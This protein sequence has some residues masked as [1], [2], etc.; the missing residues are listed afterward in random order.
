MS[1]PA[2]EVDKGFSRAGANKLP[3]HLMSQIGRAAG[4]PWESRPTLLELGNTFKKTEGG[5][6]REGQLLCLILHLLGQHR[7]LEGACHSLGTWKVSPT[8]WVCRK[9]FH[10]SRDVIIISHRHPPIYRAIAH[11]H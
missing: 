5:G 6:R 3:V 4:W 11:N 7:C 9:L 1:P 2:A 8:F 10:D